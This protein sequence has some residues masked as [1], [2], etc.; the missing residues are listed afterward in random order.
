MVLV[1]RTY[2]HCLGAMFIK[3]LTGK[4]LSLIIIII[5]I[6]SWIPVY[7]D[8]TQR[9]AVMSIGFLLSNKDDA[10]V[11]RGPKKNGMYM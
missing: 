2:S 8:D 1:Y 7:T 9:L 6:I 10:V 3:V 5:I 4:P 11:W